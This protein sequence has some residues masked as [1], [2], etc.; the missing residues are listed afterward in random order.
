M[1]VTA[2]LQYKRSPLS[3]RGH[4]RAKNEHTRLS[5][6]GAVENQHHLLEPTQHKIIVFPQNISS[7]V[8][9]RA[10]AFNHSKIARATTA[11]AI[12]H[13][14]TLQS[15]QC[16]RRPIR[17]QCLSARHASAIRKHS[18]RGAPALLRH[19]IPHPAQAR[20]EL[21]ENDTTATPPVRGQ[22]SQASPNF[23]HPSVAPPQAR[24]I[25]NH[26]GTVRALLFKRTKSKA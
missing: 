1:P 8:E 10:P 15:S 4:T 5:K 6:L 7:P 20:S 2:R 12:I 25:A 21:L 3:K 14:N 24:A 26:P 13:Q 9:K 23:C 19:D 22:A 18:Q 17:Q 16:C 11:S